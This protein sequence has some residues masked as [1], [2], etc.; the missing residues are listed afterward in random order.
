MAERVSL[1]PCGR[2]SR[3]GEKMRG[4]REFEAA[5]CCLFGEPNDKHECAWCGED[6]PDTGVAKAD[7]ERVFC[8][9][10]CSSSFQ[11]DSCPSI[12]GVLIGN[13]DIHTP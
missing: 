2:C 12:V 3:C 9:G 10:H 11:E 8:N 6:L 5:L 1:A 4:R 13:H 7:K